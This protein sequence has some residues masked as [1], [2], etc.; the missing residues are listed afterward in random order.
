M[1]ARSTRRHRA[2]SQTQSTTNPLRTRR[3]R[4]RLSADLV[5]TASRQVRL[6]Y[7]GLASLLTRSVVEYA[8][9]CFCSNSYSETVTAANASDC[10]MPCTGNSN[11][12]CGGGD[13]TQIYT[14]PSAPAQAAALPSGWYQSVAC[15]QDNANRLFYGLFQ[16]T[17]S[18]LTPARCVEACNVRRISRLAR[19]RL[20]DD[21]QNE[22]PN[23]P[24]LLAGGA[25]LP[26][27]TTGWANLALRV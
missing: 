26:Y 4:A 22:V 25:L 23:Y 13:R 20:I 27:R 6:L 2:S 21:G 7:L 24:G 16:P 17:V 3:S 12:T 14:N 8:D 10:N 1:R 19:L 5:D 9:E 15:G 18:N 11:T